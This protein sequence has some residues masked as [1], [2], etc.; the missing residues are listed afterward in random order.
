MESGLALL[1]A[2]IV[3]K[4][5]KN[6]MDVQV[7]FMFKITQYVYRTALPH[8]FGQRLSPPVLTALQTVNL[9]LQAQLVLFAMQDSKF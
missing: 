3:I 1:I 8:R 9:V 5:T 4:L 6:A 7:D 2:P